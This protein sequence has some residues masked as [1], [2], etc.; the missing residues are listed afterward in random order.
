[1]ALSKIIFSFCIVIQMSLGAFAQSEATPATNLEVEWYPPEIERSRFPERAKVIISGRTAPSSVIK[2]DGESVTVLKARSQTPPPEPAND[3]ERTL[4]ASC[5]VYELP[6]IKSR[7]LM[8]FSKGTKLKTAD[9]SE[10]W[11]KA[12][13]PKGVGYIST[14]CF[15]PAK[16]ASKSDVA[17]NSPQ[18]SDLMKIDTRE[19]RSNAE[20]FFELPIDLPLGLVQ[21]PVAVSNSRGQRTFLLSIDVSLSNIRINP[22]SNGRMAIQKPPAAGK[23]VRL[24]AGVGGT[25]QTY[26][27]TT[28][29]TSDV[30]FNTFQ[31]PG[32]LARAGYWGD[33]WGFDL[34]FRDAPGK[35][36]ADAPFQLQNDT[37]HWRTTELKG[38]YQFSRGPTSRMMGLPSQWQLRFGAQIHEVPFLDIDPTFKIDVRTHT[39][40]TATLGIGLLLAQEQDWSYE[41][42][43]GL[44]VPVSASGGG[45]NSYSISSAMGLEAQLGAAYKFAPNWRLGIFSYIQSHSYSYEFKPAS[46]ASKNGNQSLFYTTFDLRLGYEY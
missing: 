6:D 30:S 15:A 45:G 12:A 17:K 23:K 1:M 25:Y 14:P 38:L 43:L 18:Q 39:I 44:Q 7:P 5:K 37:Y 36:E 9:F 31:A 19:T 27:Q 35:I 22:A 34:Y 11:M 13:T 21:V 16:Q 40:N 24:W 20:G 32:L 28:S 42:A 3:N 8:S 10:T 29:G 41:Y 2:I 26:S 33:T 4:R 46:G